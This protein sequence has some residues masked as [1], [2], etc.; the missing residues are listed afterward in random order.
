METAKIGNALSHYYGDVRRAMRSLAASKPEAGEFFEPAW[1]IPELSES[2]ER[3]FSA[4]GLSGGS[5]G[6]YHG[7]RLLF[8]NLTGNPR[9][10]T[11]KTFGSQVI[12]ARALR[13][14]ET[15]DEPVLLVTPSAANKAVAL[16]DAVLRAYEAG[17]A[18]PETL[19]VTAIVPY[20]S[21]IK[22]WDSPLATDPALAAANP[23]G[24]YRGAERED[25]KRLLTAAYRTV[26]DEIRAATGFRAW[27]T[28]DPDNYKAADVVRASFE[29]EFFA[30]GERTRW[31]AHAV[32]SAYGFLGHNL[33]TQLSGGEPQGAANPAKYLLVQHLETPDLVMAVTGRQEL[34]AYERDAATGLLRQPEPADPR[35]PAVCYST[36]ERLERTFYTRLPPTTPAVTEL[37]RR[38]GGDGIV[39]SLPECLQRYQEVRGLLASAGMTRLPEDPRK[40]REWAMVMAVVGSLTAIDRGIL[41]ED[42]DVLVHGSGAYSEGEFE[43]PDRSVLHEVTT[44]QDVAEV[45][46]A[47]AKA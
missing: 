18:T 1:E 22:L 41:P 15:H 47:A 33:G 31:H 9:T 44:A 36:N 34:P 17:L 42:V 2:L 3:Y 7:R 4:S 19:R 27:Y 24:V 43:S 12:V 25:V 16:R 39:V 21:L 23:L 28:L 37:L 5:M 6:E 32:S 10:H 8:M 14:I 45:L 38:Q 20:S 11:T 30:P 35:F 29:R 13:H 26:A 40:L 46:L